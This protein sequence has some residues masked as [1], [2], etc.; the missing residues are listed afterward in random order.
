MCCVVAKHLPSVSLVWSPPQRVRILA[1]P[2][3]TPAP[4]AAPA[5]PTSQFCSLGT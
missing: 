1:E 4:G 5:H 3:W 2:L